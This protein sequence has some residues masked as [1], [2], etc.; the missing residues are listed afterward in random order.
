MNITQRAIAI[1]TLIATFLTLSSCRKRESPPPTVTGSGISRERVVG[2]QGG[3]LVYRVVSPPQTLNYLMARDVDSLLVSFLLMGGRLVEFDHDTLQYVPGLAE[4]WKLNDDGRTLDLKL[5]ENLRF[6]DGHNLT[7][8]DVLFTF[9]AIYDPRTAAPIFRD[10]MTIGNQEIKVS[11]SDSR[12]L[13]LVFPENIATPENYLSNVAVL[14]SHVL[15]DQLEKGQLKDAYSITSDPRQIVTSGPFMVES[16]APGERVKLKRNPYYWKQD[17][18]GNSLPYL[19]SLVLEVVP[20]SNNAIAQLQQQTLDIVDR[21]R[22]SDYAALRTQTGPVGAFDLGPGLI[23]DH[24]WFN[25]NEGMRAGKPLVDPS[26]QAWFADLRFRR[27]VAYAID[28]ESIASA[29][30]QGLATP[31]YGFVSPGNRAWVAT[32]LVRTEY[33][34]AKARALLTEAGFTARGSPAEPELYDAQGRL[35]EFTLIVPFESEPRKIMAAVIQED[36]ARIGIHMQVAAI[37]GSQLNL[38]TKESYDYEAALLGTSLTEPDPSSYTN[39]LRSNSPEH[40]WHP[41]QPKPATDWEARI[42]ALCAAQARETD[43]EKRKA[44]FREIQLIMAEQLPLIP[45]VARHVASAANVR[46]GNFRPGPIYPYS[47]WNADELFVK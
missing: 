15:G 33:D 47:L 6:S 41:K 20:D 34:L 37:E 18:A 16:A 12:N 35:V 17:P 30:L 28:R 29:N 26:K 19:D 10:A 13:R 22:P 44:T 46:I 14:P 7:A 42:D 39:F 1:L 23:T 27:A 24:L 5:R 43:A 40:Y 25:L 38:R 45:I 2:K 4:T 9:R 36:L 31:L 21:I 3:T 11:S 8:K 32:D